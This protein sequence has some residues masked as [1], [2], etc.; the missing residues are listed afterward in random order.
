ML[1]NNK[2]F[3]LIEML[4]VILIIGFLVGI[5]AI[6]ASDVGSDAK[7]KAVAADLKSLKVA[8]EAYHVQNSCFPTTGSGWEGELVGATPRLIDEVPV[9]SYSTAGADYV[10]LLEATGVYYAISSVGPGGNGSVTVGIASNGTAA[11]SSNALY[12]SN[13]A[14]GNHDFD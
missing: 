10:Y 14:N 11:G 6:R 1:K 8:V 4:L 9:D 13:C 3:T 7:K 5:L 12:V 2:G